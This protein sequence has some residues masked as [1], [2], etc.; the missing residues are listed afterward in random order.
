MGAT[1]SD[2]GNDI[3]AFNYEGI[4]E[5]HL[6]R[7]VRDILDEARAARPQKE[8]ACIAFH[9]VESG[10]VLA[11]MGPSERASAALSTLRAKD[12]LLLS[13]SVTETTSQ[14]VRTVTH[15]LVTLQ[16]SRR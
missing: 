10:Q 1:C 14:N 15:V 9:T 7:C 8:L 13:V 11:R 5:R 6:P 4:P 2:S 12:L 16:R 3:Q